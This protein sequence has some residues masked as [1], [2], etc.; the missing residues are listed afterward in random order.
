MKHMKYVVYC[1]K[2]GTVTIR[3]NM[4]CEKCNIDFDTHHDQCPICGEEFN[5][6]QQT[7]GKVM[8]SDKK[9]TIADEVM[10]DVKTKYPELTPKELSSLFS[11]LYTKARAESKVGE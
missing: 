4:H 9:Q 6:E 7:G 2:C 5:N 3:N 8:K 10:N 11:S 1:L